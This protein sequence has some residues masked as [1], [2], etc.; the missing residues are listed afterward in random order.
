MRVAFEGVMVLAAELCSLPAIE[1]RARTPPSPVREHAIEETTCHVNQQVVKVHS[2]L[3][4]VAL[5]VNLDLAFVDGHQVGLSE[6]DAVVLGPDG[7]QVREQTV[8]LLK[9]RTAKGAMVSLIPSEPGP[10]EASTA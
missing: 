5:Q 4:S 6:L 1:R 9:T 8:Q 7:M 2:A 10:Y 3:F